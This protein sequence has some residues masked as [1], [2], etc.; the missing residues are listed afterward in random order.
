MS[1]DGLIFAGSWQEWLASEP[2]FEADAVV[3]DPPFSERVHGGHRVGRRRDGQSEAELGFDSWGVR[4]VEEF[5]GAWSG[6][7][8]G[9]MAA[10]SDHQL[11]PVWISA[12]RRVGR[13]AF[14]PVPVVYRDS[15]RFRGDGPASG[16]VYLMVARPSGGR[17]LE[18]WRRSRAGLRRSLPGHYLTHRRGA[19]V[20]GGKRLDLM[21]AIIDDYSLPGDLVADPC[22]GAGTTL[23]AAISVGRRARGAEPRPPSAFTHRLRST[24]LVASSVNDE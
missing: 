17:W 19:Q 4:E 21:R 20:V 9:W 13:Y 1:G 18:Q 3:T 8:R 5:V 23:V 14:A 10:F 6:R 16:A 2:D 15:V 11:A 24:K 22:A 12:Y 7:V